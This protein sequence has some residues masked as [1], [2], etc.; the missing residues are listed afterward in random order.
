VASKILVKKVDDI[1]GSDAVDTIRLGLDGKEVD[2]D[3]NED[4]VNEVRAFL[5]PYMRAGQPV[6]A[7]GRARRSTPKQV[8]S[9]EETLAIRQW[10][11]SNGFTVSDSGALKKDLLDAYE[12]ANGNSVSSETE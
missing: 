4:R 3:L 9:K 11:R 8:R 12:A 10:G 7:S 5:D 1:D 6:K 2:I